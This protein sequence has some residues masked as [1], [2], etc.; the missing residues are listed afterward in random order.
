MEGLSLDGNDIECHRVL[1]EAF[2]SQGDLERARAHH[3]RAFTLN[4][5]DP[6]I[7]AQRGE[8]M[9][10]LGEPEKGVE[11][12]ELAMRLDPFGMRERA[13]LLGR[14]LFAARRYGEAADAYRQ[15]SYQSRPEQ[16]AE[17]AAA[18]VQAGRSS[19][20]AVEAAETIRL[21]P[22]FS[23]SA[24]VKGLTYIRDDAREHHR[25][26]LLKAGLPE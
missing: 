18:L 6:R 24:H 25:A 4:P 7:V 10:W 13:H 14:A 26:A 21:K 2:M 1:C 15:S 16:H 17:L 9:T 3:E 12:L 22:E 5:N 20:A 11:W 8:L 19:D 23:S